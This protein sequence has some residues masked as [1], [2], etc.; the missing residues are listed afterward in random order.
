MSKLNLLRSLRSGVWHINPN[1]ARGYM[2]IVAK[3]L[4]GEAVDPQEDNEEKPQPYVVLNGKSI[5]YSFHDD[6]DDYMLDTDEADDLNVTDGVHVLPIIGPIFKYDSWCEIGMETRAEQLLAADQLPQVR[7]HIL[8]IDSPGGM[9]TGVEVMQRAIAQLEK[10]IITV[11]D[12]MMCSAAMG[13]GACTER[14]F[15]S[16][17]IDVLG[18]IGTMITLV[19]DSEY[20]AQ[21]GLKIIDIYATQSV[22]KNKDYHD[23]L[24]GNQETIKAWLLDP[25]ND[26]FITGIAEARPEIDKETAYTGRIFVG[27]AALDAGLA[28]EIGDLQ[29]AIDYIMFNNKFNALTPFAKK[30]KLTSKERAELNATLKRYGIE[31]IALEPTALL[32]TGGGENPR[33]IFVYANEGEDPTGKQCVY[34]DAQG[35]ATTENL[36]DGDHLLGDGRTLTSSTHDDGL[37]YVESIKDASAAPA[38]PAPAAPAAPPANKEKTPE[39]T[40]AAISMEE[41]VKQLNSAVK[42]AV[43]NEMKQIRSEISSNGEIPVAAGKTAH[44]APRGKSPMALAKEKIEEKNKNRYK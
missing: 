2:P 3:L 28:D 22:D 19:D 23:A 24:A 32:L 10:P 14:I 30:K 35:N 29:I 31:A 18:S 42:A 7:G 39:A 12:G 26:V 36:E 34:A 37:S 43:A 38:P 8:L 5:P 44:A 15:M 11:V 1:A 4:R 41:L 27:Q 13:I 21:Q 20:L 6:D 16:N 9:S 40:P 25:T 33:N 17:N